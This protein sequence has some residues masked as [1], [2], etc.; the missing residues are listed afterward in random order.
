[1]RMV[2]LNKIDVNRWEVV[3]DGAVVGKCSVSYKHDGC[4]RAELKNGVII[5]AFNQKSLK[6]FIGKN[7]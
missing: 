4:Y 7:I 3:K 1:M 2:K 5:H 6:E